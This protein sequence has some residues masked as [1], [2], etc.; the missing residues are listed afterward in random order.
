MQRKG[1]VP[2]KVDMT[3][4]SPRTKAAER[5]RNALGGSAIPFMTLQPPGQDWTRAWRFRDLLTVGEVAKILES[6]PDAAPQA[7]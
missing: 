7:R 4:K 6:F 2:I 5:L 3:S 1:V